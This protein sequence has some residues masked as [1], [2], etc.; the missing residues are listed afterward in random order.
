M[1]GSITLRSS[2]ALFMMPPL[3]GEGTTGGIGRCGGERTCGDKSVE[4]CMRPWQL[5]SEIEF[6]YFDFSHLL[7]A[8]RE[9]IALFA[10]ITVWPLTKE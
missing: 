8:R 4:A 7:L 1:F 3:N 10:T 9:A 2:E 5:A 6:S